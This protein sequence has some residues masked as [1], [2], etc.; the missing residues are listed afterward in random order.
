MITTYISMSSGY[1]IHATPTLF[2][3]GTP[4]AQNSSC[5]L[6]YMGDS[7]D[8]IYNVLKRCAKTDS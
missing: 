5:Y 4:N 7:L 6:L 2:N 3:A 8:D 1:Y